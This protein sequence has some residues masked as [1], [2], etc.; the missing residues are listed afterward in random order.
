ML[1][2]VDPTP[3]RSVG[4]RS[5]RRGGADGQRK[6][7]NR[8]PVSTGP[9]NRDCSPAAASRASGHGRNEHPEG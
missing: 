6:T 3:E 2:V 1:W 5:L 8:G 7:A 9:T 4:F